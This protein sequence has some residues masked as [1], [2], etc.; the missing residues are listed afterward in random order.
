MYR[1]SFLALNRGVALLGLF[2]AA[3]L[4]PAARGDEPRSLLLNHGPQ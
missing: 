1:T 2:F 3:L 4:G